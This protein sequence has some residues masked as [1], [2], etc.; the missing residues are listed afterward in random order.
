MWIK[1][2]KER[3]LNQNSQV[4]S[5]KTNASPTWRAILKTKE[6]VSEGT[7]WLIENGDNISFWSDG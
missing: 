6:V 4:L 5:Q 1:V 7:K 2:I 3:Y